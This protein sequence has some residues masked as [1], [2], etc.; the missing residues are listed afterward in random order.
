MSRLLGLFA[1]ALLFAGAAAALPG[2][3]YATFSE[4]ACEPFKVPPPYSGI[5][6]WL[7]SLLKKPER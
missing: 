5:D 1:A 6:A 7:H 3:D 2:G 4:S